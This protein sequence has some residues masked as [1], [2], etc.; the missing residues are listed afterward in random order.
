M[1]LIPLQK[2][3]QFS[4][5]CLSN[6]DLSTFCDCNNIFEIGFSKSFRTG[7]RF[8][9][10]KCFFSFLQSLQFWQRARTHDMQR[11]QQQRGLAICESLFSMIFFFAKLLFLSF[12]PLFARLSGRSAR[13]VCCSQKMHIQSEGETKQT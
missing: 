3:I 13:R 5:K 12:P 11:T 2:R 10:Q 4:I 1:T 9:S 7:Q 8:F 6:I